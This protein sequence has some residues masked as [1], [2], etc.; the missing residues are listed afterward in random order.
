MTS[1]SP[2]VVHP[3]EVVEPEHVV[4]A[5]GEDAAVQR[6]LPLLPV[7]VEDAVAGDERRAL[8]ARRS[9]RVSC[10]A[11]VLLGRS[12]SCSGIHIK[13]RVARRSGQPPIPE[14]LDH[15]HVVV[16]HQAHRVGP[17][18]ASRRGGELRREALARPSSEAPQLLGSSC[19]ARRAG[20]TGRSPRR[21]RPRAP[22]AASG[23]PVDLACAGE[24]SAAS[25]KARSSWSWRMLDLVSMRTPCGAAGPS[26]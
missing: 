10:L 17:G 2:P 8:R 4:V 11:V 14:L 16:E 18:T 26:G 9:R 3:V 1:A 12:A 21:A 22:I 23:A 7:P 5:G 15:A 6:E 19:I 25:P 20:R 13:P 24:A